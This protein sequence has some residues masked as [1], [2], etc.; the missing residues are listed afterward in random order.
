[1]TMETKYVCDGCGKAHPGTPRKYGTDLY[2][3]SKQLVEFTFSNDC[4]GLV[5]LKIHVC[6]PCLNKAGWQIATTFPRNSGTRSSDAVF[7]R[8]EKNVKKVFTDFLKSV[9][10]GREKKQNTG[11]QATQMSDQMACAPCDLVYDMN[12]PN[13]PNCLLKEKKKDGP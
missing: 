2:L 10:T 7:D 12:D 11:C 8:L 9:E 13:P 6:F 3:S 1:M 4:D 5:N